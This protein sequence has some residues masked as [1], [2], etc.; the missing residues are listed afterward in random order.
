MAFTDG[1]VCEESA[2]DYPEV[3]GLHRRYF[4]MHSFIARYLVDVPC[5]A[6]ASLSP[7]ASTG[8]RRGAG[9][10]RTPVPPAPERH[11][12][13]DPCHVE[14]ERGDGSGSGQPLVD[15]FDIDQSLPSGSRTSQTPL[16]SGLGFSSFQ[17]PHSTSYGFFGFRVPP[18]R[19]QLVH[20]YRISL[21]HRHVRLIKRSGRMT[22]MVLQRYRFGHRVGKKTKRFTPF[23][24]P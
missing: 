2:N 10:G 4:G 9:G 16:P 7:G 13:V 1:P 22:W 23:D 17:A 12:H 15:P 3:Y 21:Y 5:A 18:L 11:E 20:L 6:T 14:M 8:L 19:A 24:C